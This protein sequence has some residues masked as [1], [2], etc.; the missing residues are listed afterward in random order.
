MQAPDESLGP[1]SFLIGLRLARVFAEIHILPGHSP[2]SSATWA[3][4][5]SIR[6]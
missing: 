4:G 2:V 5:I 1:F 6:Q 3:E